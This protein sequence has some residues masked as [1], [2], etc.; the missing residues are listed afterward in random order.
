MAYSYEIVLREAL[1]RSTGKRFFGQ[2]YVIVSTE[3][4]DLFSIS[5]TYYP[6]T[7]PTPRTN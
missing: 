2:R 6:L 3:D 7:N 4:H 1:I 5:F